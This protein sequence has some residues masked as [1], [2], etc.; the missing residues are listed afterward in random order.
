MDPGPRSGGITSSSKTAQRTKL[1]RPSRTP[2]STGKCKS[3]CLMNQA[4]DFAGRRGDVQHQPPAAAWDIVRVGHE[5]SPRVPWGRP[6]GIGCGP[7]Y[8][9]RT[10]RP[11]VGHGATAGPYRGH[12]RWS[13]LGPCNAGKGLGQRVRSAGMVELGDGLDRVRPEIGWFGSFRPPWILAL[14]EIVNGGRS[15][16]AHRPGMGTAMRSPAAA[17]GIAPTIPNLAGS[18][19][20]SRRTAPRPLPVA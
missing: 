6:A 2:G 19:E 13:A 8:V 20:S 1:S 5:A 18:L 16:S 9:R 12:D 14:V 7:A 4:G 15:R 17:P 10:G 11:R 3:P